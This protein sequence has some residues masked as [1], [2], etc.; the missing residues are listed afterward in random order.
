NYSYNNNFIPN[1]LT[2]AGET[3]NFIYNK[4][5]LLIQSGEFTLT[6]DID[7]GQV[8]QLKDGTITQKRKHN[9]YGELNEIE[10][11]LFEYR[12]KRDN[13]KISSKTET[14]T[15]EIPK[16]NGKGTQKVKERTKYGILGSE[17]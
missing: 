16:Q 15:K 7:S 8:K 10:D 2:Y 17:S 11:D 14:I 4:D 1:S 12:L 6:R 9:N 5:N 3:T 13:L